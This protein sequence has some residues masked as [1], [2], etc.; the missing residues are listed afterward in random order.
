MHSRIF[1]LKNDK[2]AANDLTESSIDYG[3]MQMHGIDYVAKMDHNEIADS[4]N[5]LAGCYRNSVTIDTVTNELRFTDAK[6][7]MKQSF[8]E[9]QEVLKIL[10]TMTID[11]FIEEYHTDPTTG[12]IN[13]PLSSIS[14]NMYRLKTA[15][16]DESGFYIYTEEN[17]L[18][19]IN[20]FVR[21]FIGD[22]TKQTFYIGNVLDYHC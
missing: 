3:T 12:Q 20:G 17:G 16:E 1:E 18:Q 4:V 13:N 11:D 14:F 5:W 9:F 2:N 21:T 6:A 22:I 7:L 8:A 19:T 10:S 15:Y